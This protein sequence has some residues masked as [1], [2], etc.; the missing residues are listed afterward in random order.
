[1]FISF[2]VCFLFCYGY[3]IPLYKYIIKTEYFTKYHCTSTERIVQFI[4]LC[5][6]KNYC[7]MKDNKTGGTI[8]LWKQRARQEQEQIINT[9]QRLMIEL[10]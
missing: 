1:M 5:N 3:I 7:I 6:V 9:M 10:L 8:V 2:V 4:Q